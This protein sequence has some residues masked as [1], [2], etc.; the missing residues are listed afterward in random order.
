[1]IVFTMFGLLHG[2]PFIRLYPTPEKVITLDIS[3]V[4]L[5]IFLPM[6]TVVDFI[7]GVSTFPYFK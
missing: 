2:G 5:A 6:Y 4:L 7:T 3:Q 1:M